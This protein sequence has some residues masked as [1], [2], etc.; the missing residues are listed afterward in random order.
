VWADLGL[1]GGSGA[2]CAIRSAPEALIVY[3]QSSMTMP[4]LIGHTGSAGSGVL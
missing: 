1:F 3:A 2:D 4:A